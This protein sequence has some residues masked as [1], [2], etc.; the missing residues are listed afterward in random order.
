MRIGV[1]GGGRIG[2]TLARLLVAAGDEVAIANSRGPGSLAGLVAELG[3]RA[4]AGS[5]E[6]TAAFGELIVVAI[7]LHAVDNLPAGR[8]DGKIAIDANNYYAGRDGSRPEL[9][10]DSTSSSSRAHGS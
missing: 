7:P 4:Q 2:G 5:V 1:I 10:S 3:D 8:F 6:D 9:D